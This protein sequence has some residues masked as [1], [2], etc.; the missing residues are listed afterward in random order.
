MTLTV[1]VKNTSVNSDPVVITSIWGAFPAF[2]GNVKVPHNGKCDRV[3]PLIIQL[4]AELICSSELEVTGC[5]KLPDDVHES[6]LYDP[7]I[8]VTVQGFDN[9]HVP[10]SRSKSIKITMIRNIVTT[11]TPTDDSIIPY[12]P[13]YSISS[14][15]FTFTPFEPYISLERAPNRLTA[16]CNTVSPGYQICVGFSYGF[17]DQTL[18]ASFREPQPS[19][20]QSSP[21][22]FMISL[23]QYQLNHCPTYL[24]IASTF[25]LR[26]MICSF[27]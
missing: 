3:L 27:V 7:V 8:S 2:V 6:A 12:Y 18:V 15:S 16:G 22:I 14:G 5:D 9:E 25:H 24:L 1:T 21:E 17:D 10:L 13:P 11:P 19:G 4:G 23:L 20:N 26:L